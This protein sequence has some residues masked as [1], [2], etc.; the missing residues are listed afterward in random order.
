MWIQSNRQSSH[1]LSTLRTTTL[2]VSRIIA[3]VTTRRHGMREDDTL[4]LVRSL[5][6]SRVT[7]SLP[8][9]HLTKA[10]SY[11]KRNWPPKSP[12]LR[13]LLPAGTY[14]SAL[15]IWEISLN[16]SLFHQISTQPTRLPPYPVIWILN[17]T[18][19]GGRPESRLYGN[20]T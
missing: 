18:M 6:F 12:G 15:G 9:Q 3:R 19:A 10:E 2:Q 17:S 7:Y 14:C 4:K 13:R 5:V 1:T 11:G 20:N 8:Y 16:N